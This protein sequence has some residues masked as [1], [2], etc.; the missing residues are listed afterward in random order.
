MKIV[1]TCHT[2]YK[3]GYTLGPL[4]NGGYNTY[5]TDKVDYH[6]EITPSSFSKVSDY[7]ITS[8]DG[9]F[10]FTMTREEFRRCFTIRS[11]TRNRKLKELG[12]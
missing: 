10:A 9:M 3:P 12:I 8:L 4:K 1:C 5:V 2:E 6:L 7:N 11:H